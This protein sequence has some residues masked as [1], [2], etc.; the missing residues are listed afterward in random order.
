MDPMEIIQLANA[1][2]ALKRNG[3]GFKDAL[4]TIVGPHSSTD[5]KINTL[6]KDVAGECSR[7]A[8]LAKQRLQGRNR[9]PKKPTV[10]QRETPQQLQFGFKGGKLKPRHSPNPNARIV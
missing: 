5:L 8:R 10:L 7:R 1:V 9:P 4:N 3:V 6:R 2:A